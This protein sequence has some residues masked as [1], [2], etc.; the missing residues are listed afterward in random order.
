M[1]KAFF[2][3]VLCGAVSGFLASAANIWQNR[4]D[5][6]RPPRRPARDKKRPPDWW[7]EY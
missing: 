7:F 5:R 4:A 2:A 1:I 3:C 6:W